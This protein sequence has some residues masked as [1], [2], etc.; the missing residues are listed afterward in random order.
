MAN[1]TRRELLLKRNEV[2]LP[3]AL[4]NP[5]LRSDFDVVEGQQYSP[6]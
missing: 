4:N 2:A 6:S 3:T 1:T 5:Q